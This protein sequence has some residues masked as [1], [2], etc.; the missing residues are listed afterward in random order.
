MRNEE[1]KEKILRSSSAKPA[2][3]YLFSMF[4][5]SKPLRGRQEPA[6]LSLLCEADNDQ[7][8][9]RGTI[10]SD[11]YQQSM[12]PKKDERNSRLKSDGFLRSVNI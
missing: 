7:K 5:N 3:L 2:F 9:P 11:K 10:N 6:S 4:S 8:V 12:C 1:K